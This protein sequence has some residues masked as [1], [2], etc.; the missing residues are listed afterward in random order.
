[1]LQEQLHAA[2][3]QAQQAQAAQ[4]EVQQQL[5]ELQLRQQQHRDWHALLQACAQ[6]AGSLMFG[7]PNVACAAPHTCRIAQSALVRL[8]YVQQVNLPLNV[9][10]A[11]PSASW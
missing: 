4:K 5:E 9:S 7:H 1:M 2:Q 10:H 8:W 6:A 11:E 3:Q